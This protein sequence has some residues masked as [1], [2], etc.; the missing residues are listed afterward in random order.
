MLR[1]GFEAQLKAMPAI[2]GTRHSE[3]PSII[4]LLEQAQNS[5]VE[6]YESYRIEY[7]V[8]D[9]VVFIGDREGDLIDYRYRKK[10]VR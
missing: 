8:R 5:V 9:F 7:D 3:K 2:V 1:A 6:L 10:C 4:D